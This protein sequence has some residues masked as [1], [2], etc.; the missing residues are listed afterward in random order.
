LAYQA[1]QCGA[2]GVDM[3]RNIFQCE[4][5]AAMIQAVRAIVH[6][7]KNVG[8]AYDLFESLRRNY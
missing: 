3:G 7:N 1:I 6:E 2:C 8:E 4:N 5:P